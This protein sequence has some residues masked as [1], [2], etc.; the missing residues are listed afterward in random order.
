MIND[1]DYEEIKFPV[2]KKYYCRIESKTI[3][4]LKYF[5]M[6]MD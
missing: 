3:F 4:A 1:R 2:S 6:K 5:V